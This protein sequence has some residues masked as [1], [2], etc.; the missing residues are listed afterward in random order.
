MDSATCRL[1]KPLNAGRRFALI[2]MKFRIA[3]WAAP[4]LLVWL[5]NPP[6]KAAEVPWDSAAPEQSGFRSDALRALAENLAARNT[7]CF[8]VARHGKIIYEWYA[9][10]AGVEKPHYTASLAKALVGGMSLLAALNDGRLSADDPAWKFIPAWKNDPQRSKITIRHLATHSSGIEDAEEDGKPHA[11]LAGWKGAFWKRQEDPFLISLASAPVIFEPGSRYHYSNTGMAALAYAV[12]ASLRGAP[13]PDIL[14]VLRDRVMRPIGVPDGQWSISYGRVWERDGLKLY[15]NW[16]GGSFTARAAARVGQ[17]MLQGG[18]WEGRRLF[19]APVVRQM[20]APAGTPLPDRS[21]GHPAPASGLCWWVNADGVWPSVPKDAFAG[22]GAG[23]QVL[24]V[25]PSLNLVA[26]R[27]GGSLSGKGGREGFWTPVYQHLMAPLMAAM[28]LSAPYPPSPVIKEIKFAP[29]SSIVQKAI[30]SDNWPITWMDDDTQFTAYGDG[31]G[32]EPRTDK[33]LSLGFAQIIGP[34]ESFKAVNVR[35]PT[36]ERTGEGKAGAKAS[37][38]LMVDGVLYMWVR[39]TGNSQLVWSLDRGR[40]WQWGFKFDVSFGSPAFL[41][42]GKNYQGARDEFVYTYSQDG[43]SA[44]ES[45]DYLVLARAPKDRLRERGAWE[46]F[47][48]LDGAQ[49][50]V[51][52]KDIAQR[53]P[54]FTFR[55]H[56]ERVDAVYNPYIKRYLLALGYNHQGGWGI[57]DAPEPWG[58]WTT[59]FH[60]ANWGLGGTHGYRLPAK[61]IQPGG[62]TMYLIFSGIKPYDAFCLRR[63]TLELHAAR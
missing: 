53:G 37:G 49:Q 7:K 52:T 43:P 32:F 2:L 15:A 42:F 51:W 60:T 45:Y 10:D 27:N 41:N 35:S 9:P 16:G 36:G 4:V 29:E 39:N 22:A 63:F 13:Q 31:W 30:D 25:I 17:L 46:F 12:T 3:F 50:P 59:A 34:P 23:H 26:V 61:W 40:T 44:Y 33:K 18:V 47:V 8:L 55:G 14:S 19:K 21:G 24:L 20:V 1:A 28:D 5:G 11:E 62:T 38:M 48:R 6:L 57:Y 58:P 54:V 56:C